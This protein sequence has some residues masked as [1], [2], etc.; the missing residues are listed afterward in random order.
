MESYGSLTASIG[1][2]WKSVRHIC[3]ICYA[4]KSSQVQFLFILSD[5]M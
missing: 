3:V 4:K 5:C 2:D 1:G